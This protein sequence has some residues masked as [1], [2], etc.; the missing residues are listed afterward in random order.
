[1]YDTLKAKADERLGMPAYF[2]FLTLLGTPVVTGGD[3]YALVFLLHNNTGAF[4]TA[5]NRLHPNPL[6]HTRS[7]VG[8]C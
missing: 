2:R 8:V 6:H 7:P 4:T 5:S 3:V 1:M